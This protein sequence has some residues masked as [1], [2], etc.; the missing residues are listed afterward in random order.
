MNPVPFDSVFNASSHTWSWGSPDILPMF[1][2]GASDPARIDTECYDEDMEDFTSDATELDSWVF[3]RVAGMFEEAGRNE[4]LDAMLRGE[5]VVFFLHLLGLDTTGHAY[6]PYSREYLRNIR[7]VDEGL[8]RIHRLV[9]EFY[10][11][12]EKTAWV[13]TADHG[14]SDWGS[15]GD[16]HPDNTRTPL[17][18]WGAG[19]KKPVGVQE[20]EGATGHEDGFSAD[21]GLDAVRRVDVAQADVAALMAYLVGVRFPVNS[22]GELP[23]EYLDA[24]EEV[25]AEAAW[26]NARQIAE[27]Y[28]VKEG[29]FARVIFH[30]GYY[31]ADNKQNRRRPPCSTSSPSPPS[32]RVPT[33]SKP[34]SWRFAFLSTLVPTRLLSSSPKS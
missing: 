27:M 14:M 7:I 5:K 23:L 29:E 3:E 4:T 19:V 21:W 9:N 13:F 24:S 15:H 26:T 16:G 6:R 25:K 2:E 34:A 33:P 32:A 20:V 31:E 28:W 8:E 11:H 12:D 17:V 10:G 1:K 18:A 22:V 30:D